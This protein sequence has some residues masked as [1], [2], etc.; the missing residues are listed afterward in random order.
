[1]SL[2]LRFTAASGGSASFTFT[3]ILKEAGVYEVLY[4]ADGIIESGMLPIL[5]SGLKKLFAETRREQRTT[6]QNRNPHQVA[7][8]WLAVL[9]EELQRYPDQIITIHQ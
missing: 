7:A 5:K 4:A 9:I 8:L 6:E 3:T 2:Q 1:M